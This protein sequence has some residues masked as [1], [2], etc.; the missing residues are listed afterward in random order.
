MLSS[1]LH[2]HTALRS[3]LS[4]IAEGEQAAGSVGAV[5]QVLE[6]IREQMQTATACVFAPHRVGQ[7][8]AAPWQVPQAGLEYHAGV[9]D[10]PSAAFF[11]DYKSW[12]WKI[13]VWRLA[14]QKNMGMVAAQGGALS[15]DL[16]SLP[17]LRRTQ[18][19]ADYLTR[20]VGG[21]EHMM[22]ALLAGGHVLGFMR[23]DG[24]KAFTLDD[25]A[26]VQ[27]FKQPLERF[28]QTQLRA[29]QQQLAV[30]HAHA[31]LD[32]VH[33]GVLLAD[34]SSAVLTANTA[35]CKYLGM[36][37]GALRES[38]SCLAQLLAPARPRMQLLH[39]PLWKLALN[40]RHR[41]Q[42]GV[43][44][45]S[46]AGNARELSV[47][48]HW[49]NASGA[50]A[51]VHI[52]LRLPG[53][54]NPAQQVQRCAHSHHLTETESRVLAGLIDNTPQE[55]ACALGLKIS[56]VRTHMAGIY[57]KTGTRRQAELIWLVASS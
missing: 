2:R 28:I 38:P 43:G 6:R 37:L 20:S 29:E 39:P 41:G 57:A 19:H 23:S 33:D 8:P 22:C 55:V 51:R 1:T 42:A 7:A 18:F 34:A 48:V 54:L 26:L 46:G 24:Q 50:P 4:A 5:E 40:A 9:Q 14:L 13:D 3:T 49:E 32:R 15:Q 44:Q 36:P 30:A 25:L 10:I 11:S 53:Q 35:A 45:I 17:E 21:M 31:A 16:V 27:Q 47:Q 12:V 56:T 52:L